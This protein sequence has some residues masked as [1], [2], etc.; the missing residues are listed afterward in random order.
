MTA[1]QYYIEAG[2]RR[3][4]AAR[5][6]GL[7]TISAILHEDG[8]PSTPVTVNISDLFSPKAS[9]SR[10]DARYVKVL[11]GMSSPRTRALVPAID[12]Q[13]LSVPKQTSSVPL[14]QVTLDP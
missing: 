4:V 14:S 12:I 6:L 5:E 10:S 1:L 2:V 8:K 7:P 13:P 3:A 9:I 11:G